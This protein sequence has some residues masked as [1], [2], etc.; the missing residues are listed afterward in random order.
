M[1]RTSSAK[2]RIAA[3][4]LAL[5]GVAGC[6][7]SVTWVD[8]PK[9]WARSFTLK[10]PEG[11]R[12]ERSWYWRSPHFTR[13][14]AYDFAFTAPAEVELSLRLQN[15]RQPL[16]GDPVTAL[17]DKSCFDRPDGFPEPGAAGFDVWV[18]EDGALHRNRSSGRLYLSACQM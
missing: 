14:E 17:R 5:L 16:T 10:P 13:E 2:I 8:D 15:G 11:V 12:L 9:D 4:A 7:A 6:R 1:R 18:F 3:W